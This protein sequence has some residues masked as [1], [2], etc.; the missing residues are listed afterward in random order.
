MHEQCLEF[1]MH[2]PFGA[3]ETK[4]DKVAVHFLYE[5]SSRVGCKQ[6]RQGC[7]IACPVGASNS[8][9]RHVVLM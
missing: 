1:T 4:L 8:A 7:G 5:L 9:G 6:G 2:K 3:T